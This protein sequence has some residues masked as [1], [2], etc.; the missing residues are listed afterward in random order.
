MDPDRYDMTRTV[1]RRLAAD[2][3]AGRRVGNLS[4]TVAGT[5]MAVLK[6]LDDDPRGRKPVP[7]PAPKQPGDAQ[8]PAAEAQAVVRRELEPVG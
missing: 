6:R 1:L 3:A 7:I 2:L 4:P 8:R 5:L